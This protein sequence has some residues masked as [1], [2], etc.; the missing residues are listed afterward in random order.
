MRILSHF[1]VVVHILYIY[2]YIYIYIYTKV[3]VE[4]KSDEI[5]TL[6][7]QKTKLVERLA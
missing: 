4:M 2:I 1:Y 7:K 6:N 5:L 3:M